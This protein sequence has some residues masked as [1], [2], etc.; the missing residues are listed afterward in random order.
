[1]PG[2][3]LKIVAGCL[4]ALIAW[5]ADAAA[6][7]FEAHAQAF[8]TQ[9]CAECHDAA[10]KEGALDLAALGRDLSDAETLRRWVRIYDRVADREMPPRDAPQPEAAVK[11]AFL[12]SIG[13][14]L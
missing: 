9:H 11:K 6:E 2:F 3:I 12:A 8:F 13:P 7:E 5:A 10:T 1:M 14:R 4:A